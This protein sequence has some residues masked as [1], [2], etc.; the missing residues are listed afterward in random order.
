MESKVPF[1]PTLALPPTSPIILLLARISTSRELIGSIPSFVS[2]QSFQSCLI[3]SLPSSLSFPGPRP[4]SF[5]QLFLNKCNALVG[6]FP[7]SRL[8]LWDPP[9]FLLLATLTSHPFHVS[10]TKRPSAMAFPRLYLWVLPL[11][12]MPFHLPTCRLNPASW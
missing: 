3:V 2:T 8:F 5:I 11:I 7:A 12:T 4:L 9:F 10:L 1:F 6:P